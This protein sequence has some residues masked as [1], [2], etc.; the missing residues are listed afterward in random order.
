MVGAIALDK[1]GRAEPSL[2][3]D[4]AGI[5]EAIAVDIW[6]KVSKSMIALHETRMVKAMNEYI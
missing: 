3:L 2:L 4:K 6:S 5:V 1:T